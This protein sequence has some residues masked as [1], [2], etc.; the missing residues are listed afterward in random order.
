MAEIFRTRDVVVFYKGDSYAV[1]LDSA[2]RASGWAGG[3]AVEWVDS[4]RDEF[5][6]G[7]STGLYGGFLLWGSDEDSDSYISFTNSQPAVGYGVMGLG[8]WVLSTRT[9]E[10]YTYASRQAGPLVPLTYIPGERLVFSLRGLWT[11]ED[12][13]SLSG[14]PRGAN[15][16][17]NANVIQAPT[18]AN[19][20]FMT[21]QTSI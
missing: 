14:D 9:F 13:W 15:T 21:L 19:K 7:R 3:Q 6:A 8:N 11:K 5:L 18:A 10:M 1:A 4:T 20:Y 12:E 17:F 16:F 2:L